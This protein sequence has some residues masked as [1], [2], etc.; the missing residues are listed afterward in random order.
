MILVVHLPYD[1]TEESASALSLA[2]RAPSF[3]IVQT[4]MRRTAVV[5]FPSLPTHIDLAVELVGE[6]VRLP[7]A[8]ATVNATPLS[9]L[10]KLWQRLTC[11]R[12]S[13][14]AADPARYCRE[15]AAH[16]HRLVGCDGVHCPVSCQFICTP[17]LGL[18]A[19]EGGA[20]LIVPQK[21]YQAAAQLAEVDWCPRLK[22]HL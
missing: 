11:Y 20:P 1:T 17:C 14:G 5:T 13:L 22:I 19:Q 10:T 16:F 6:A 7:E 2:R 9:S 21:R 4:R 15:Q 12:G 3:A 18:L 8:W